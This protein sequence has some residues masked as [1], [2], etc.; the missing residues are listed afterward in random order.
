[1]GKK[2]SDKEF[3]N[4]VKKKVDW[5][6]EFLE[7]YDSKKESIFVRCKNGHSVSVRT[8]KLTRTEGWIKNCPKCSE[9]ETRE[10]YESNPKTC[11]HCGNP[12]L[13]YYSSKETREKDFCS[14]SCSAKFNNPLNKEVRHCLNCNKE[15]EWWEKKFCSRSCDWDN[16]YK[17]EI[18]K[19]KSGEIVFKTEDIPSRVRKYL[20]EKNNNKCEKCEWSE[21]NIHTNKIP[22]QVHH[23][24]GNH[25]NN[26]ESNLQLLCPNCH[27]LTETYGSRNKGNGRDKRREWRKKYSKSS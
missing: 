14:H 15:L 25:K 23:I 10:E 8:K 22:L 9:V 18:L 3:R 12:I 26:I 4:L 5:I 13:F 6:L 24:D 27:S 17:E 7:D 11:K 21:N 19:W 16:R 20:F 2:Y 1:M